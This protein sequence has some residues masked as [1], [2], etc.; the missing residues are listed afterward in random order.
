MVHHISIHYSMEAGR[1]LRNKLP[2]N[3]KND[4]LNIFQSSI[5][6]YLDKNSFYKVQEFMAL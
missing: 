6:N 1:K 3:I 5:K 2:S 4:N